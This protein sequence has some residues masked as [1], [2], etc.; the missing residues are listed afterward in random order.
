MWAHD[1]ILLLV[2][3]QCFFNSYSFV[4][5]T[6]CCNNWS[7]SGCHW[8]Q[9]PH[10]FSQSFS[11]LHHFF[12]ISRHLFNQ[13][14]LWLTY[15]FAFSLQSGVQPNSFKLKMELTECRSDAI[16]Y[17]VMAQ[18]KD[19]DNKCDENNLPIPQRIPGFANHLSNHKVCWQNRL[20]LNISLRGSQTFNLY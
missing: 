4:E 16:L 13:R 20:S 19:G 5:I 18:I 12:S 17:K 14:P 7:Q 10:T 11:P 3:W 1:S 8:K 9:L 6:R 2:W 15:I